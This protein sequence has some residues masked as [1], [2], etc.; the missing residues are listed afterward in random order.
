LVRGCRAV[1][2]ALTVLVGSVAF[3]PARPAF[4]AV[5]AFAGTCSA[6]GGI[7]F[8]ATLSATAVRMT[9]AVFGLGGT[10]IVVGKDGADTAAPFSVTLSVFSQAPGVTCA[11]GVF[12]GELRFSVDGVGFTPQTVMVNSSG[13]LSVTAASATF[14]AVGELTR[15][16]STCPA[17]GT[18][19]GQFVIEDPTL[20]GV[21]GP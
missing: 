20:D 10:C 4:G 17:D 14:A 1:G 13:V 12:T 9:N 21:D 2:A 15:G 18:W 8:S 5:N 3:A 11:A 6:A 19:S 7:D 16:T